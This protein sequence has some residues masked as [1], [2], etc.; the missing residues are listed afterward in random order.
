M[1]TQILSALPDER[2]Q[3]IRDRLTLGRRVLAA[4]LAREFETSEDTIRRDLRELAAAGLC[5]RVYGGAL[6]LSPASASLAERF[7]EARERKASLGRA[8]ALLVA[9]GQVAFIDAGSTN[10]AIAQALPAGVTVATNAPHIAAA[11]AGRPEIELMLIGGRVD[12]RSG[13]ALGARAL[14]DAGE[15]RADIAFLGACAVDAVAGVAAFDPEEAAF[16]RLIAERACAVVAAATTDKL[17]VRAPFEVGPVSLIDHLVVEAD[18]PEQTL[19]PLR[20]AGVRV[21]RAF[22]AKEFEA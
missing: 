8:A 7:A 10:A 16:K 3:T 1:T 9:P 22:P 4:E 13:A 5:R 12:P 6:P 2:R 14:R 18:A 11:L 21:L 20:A 15:I 17:G 19:A